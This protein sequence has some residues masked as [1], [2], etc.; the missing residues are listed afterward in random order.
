M[1]ALKII[2]QHIVET[3]QLVVIGDYDPKRHV[4]RVDFLDTAAIADANTLYICSDP[5]ILHY[6]HVQ[7]LMQATTEPLM[8]LAQGHETHST[9]VIQLSRM[10][11]PV[12]LFSCI[13]E[14]L[15]FE[16][17]IQQEVN[18][19][20]YLLHEGRGLD[21]LA[22][23]SESLLNHPISIL[24]ASYSMIAVS[25][26]MRH[27][28]F[29]L[30]TSEDGI[31]LSAQEVES[32]RRLQ[33]EHKIYNNNQAFFIQTEDHP[34]TNWIFCAI[35][36]QHVMSGYVAVCLPKQAIA[37][38]YELRITTAIAGICAIEMQKHEF[39]VQR[40]GMQ[41]ETFLTELI[42]GR[43]NDVNMIE[44][45]LRLL[46]RRFGKF[47]CLA[48]LYCME[49]HNS[50]LFN[51]RQMSTLRQV[52]P[53]CMSVVYKNNIVLLIN[54]DT[55]VQLSA[56][57]TAPLEQFARRN[58][59]KVSLSQPFADILKIRIFYEQALHTLE[60]SDMSLP[61]Q[62]LYFSTDALPQY[63]FSNCDYQGLEIGIHYHIFQLMDYDKEYHTDFIT[64]LRAYLDNDRNATKTAEFL[65][66]H[67]STFFYR[68]KKIEELLDISISDS[69]L[70]FLYELS[71][72]IWDY[73][74]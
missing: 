28:P 74:C 37:S 72:N 57:L 44:S 3:Y 53:N 24:D 32:L 54:Q 51:K 68:I 60:L 46:N 63:L 1:V 10:P 50:D 2:I 61:E 52:Y 67:R 13:N 69:H 73:L 29:G 66:I 38:E 64:T 25:P 9:P 42:E 30:E 20:Y 11:N 15:K 31:F 34:D 59:L 18:G 27:L 19:L 65:H 21:E 58:H 39:F 71:F 26:M 45:R 55:P 43:F 6:K 7:N 40:T 12:E 16:S 62:Y 49:P 47:F 70:L 35:R 8:I 48:V 22:K 4:N 23:Q 41:Y 14:K 5:Q 36:I 17:Q 33:I 56:E